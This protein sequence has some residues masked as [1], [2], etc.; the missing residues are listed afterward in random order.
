MREWERRRLDNAPR[1]PRRA[2]AHAPGPPLTPEYIYHLYR[3]FGPYIRLV[4]GE[5]G[6]EKHKGTLQQYMKTKERPDGIPA[7]KVSFRCARRTAR[8]AVRLSIC[9]LV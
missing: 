3:Q 7:W 2:A 4:L 9:A 8:C 5:P 1:P 6:D